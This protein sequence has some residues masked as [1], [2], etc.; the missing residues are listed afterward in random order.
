MVS[1]L[2]LVCAVWK[3]VM[4]WWLNNPNW[5]YVVDVWGLQVLHGKWSFWR[6]VENNEN[7]ML[8]QPWLDLTKLLDLVEQE[9][10]SYWSHSDLS[11]DRHSNSLKSL[12][13]LERT[14]RVFCFKREL[15]YHSNVFI[16]VFFWFQSLYKALV[17]LLYI[18]CKIKLI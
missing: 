13:L 15:L 2:F 11:L 7:L 3:D 18:W 12:D 16:C 8:A 5:E 4:L 9:I 17:Y 10:R 6:L 1:K 14:C